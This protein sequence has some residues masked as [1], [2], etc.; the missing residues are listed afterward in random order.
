M[1]FIEIILEII[2]T[3]VSLFGSFFHTTESINNF[4]KEVGEP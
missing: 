2:L 1:F 4:A 3:I